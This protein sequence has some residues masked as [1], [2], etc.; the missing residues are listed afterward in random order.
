M[1]TAVTTI[2]ISRGGMSVGGRNDLL[3]W[4]LAYTLNYGWS[5][6]PLIFGDKRPAIK[7][8]AHQQKRADREQLE[9]WFEGD[10]HN[11]GLVTGKVSGIVVIDVDREDGWE[12]LL[13]YGITRGMDTPTVTTPKGEH[14]YFQYP[15][16]NVVGLDGQ[17]IC[18]NNVG[19]VPGC[20]F[21][22][23][24]GYVVAP[25]SVNG[26]GLA[27][28]WKIRPDQAKPLPLPERYI[29]SVL[30]SN[31]VTPI[32]T[33]DSSID[34]SIDGSCSIESI[35]NSPNNYV[36]FNEGTRDRSLW[37][38]AA[39]LKQGGMSKKDAAEVLENV[40]ES[41][42]P[43]F[44]KRQMLDKIKSAYDRL[45]PSER[46]LSHEI[47]EW[48]LSTNGHF[49]STEVYQCLQLS[50]R[51]EKKNCSKVLSQ[52][53]EET[54]IE[55]HGKKNGV[56]RRVEKHLERLKWQDVEPDMTLPIEWPFQIEQY[57]RIT[58]RTLIV[59]AGGK[60]AGKTAMMFNLIRM[61]QS[62]FPIRYFSS[63]LGAEMLRLR[64]DQ[65]DGM[66]THD[67]NFEAYYRS[68]GFADVVDPAG[69]N[70]IDYLPVLEDFWSVGV[71]LRAIFDKLTTGVAVVALQKQ[72][73]GKNYDVDLARGGQFTLDLATLYLVMDP[74]RLKIYDAKIWGDPMETPNGKVFE[75]KL[76]KGCKFIEQ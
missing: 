59:I 54:V 31:I 68:T 28:K 23:D 11:E 14:L 22:G 51:L 37:Y 29:Q 62:R 26:N 10:N 5:V 27:Y 64:L 18:R 15:G 21:R 1:G 46:N 49:S 41:C 6:I 76:V 19:K 17:T 57:A 9:T 25:P 72:R 24:G 48:V 44:P 43:P 47:R 56:F 71:E 75:Y 67:W 66:K 16:N 3:D 2:L 8:E 65:F 32:E 34:V 20:D 50:T 55:R 30:L 12:A 52:L 42:S 69:L 33:I 36:N 7:W 70:L 58:P 60:S 38:V 4:A 61:N 74:G 45:L 40:A 63:E 35:V 13:K 39:C 73:S 53:V